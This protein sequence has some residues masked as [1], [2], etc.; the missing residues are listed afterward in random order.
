MSVYDPLPRA[1]AFASMTEDQLHT[2]MNTECAAVPPR[3]SVL[4]F[5]ARLGADTRVHNTA[6]LRAVADGRIRPSM[7]QVL[8]WV[9]QPSHHVPP[10]LC[11]SIVVSTLSIIFSPPHRHT[12]S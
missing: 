1:A 8:A 10:S 9:Q 4:G 2:A 3:R 7:I 5:A 6:T 12:A 11:S